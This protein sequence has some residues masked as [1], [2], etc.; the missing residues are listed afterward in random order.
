MLELEN[1]YYKAFLLPHRHD[2]VLPHHMSIIGWKYVKRI[3]RPK[4][5][6]PFYINQ[7]IGKGTPVYAI[8][9]GTITC[10]QA[11]RTY[12]GVKYLTS[13]GNYIEFKSLTGGYTE[14]EYV[15]IRHLLSKGFFDNRR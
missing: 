9:D 14:M 3:T 12:S 15:L 2:G 11:F 6:A 4:V 8:A 13:Y 5:C 7:N 10:K 1:L